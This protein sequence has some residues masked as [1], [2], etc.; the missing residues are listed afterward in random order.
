VKS[1]LF[2]NF[3]TCQLFL[4]FSDQLV[5]HDN[6]SLHVQGPNA[7]C[8]VLESKSRGETANTFD[9][10]LKVIVI[11]QA[12]AILGMKYSNKI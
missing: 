6:L 9:F 4:D 8:E 12:K 2:T 3:A 7:P 5:T 10:Y 11:R 1:N